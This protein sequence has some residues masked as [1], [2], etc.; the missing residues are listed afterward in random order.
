MQYRTT[1]AATGAYRM[2]QTGSH[3][4]DLIV[5]LL[6]AAIVALLRAGDSRRNGRLDAELAELETIS[7]IM[8]G[9]NGALDRGR[10]FPLIAHLERFYLTTSFQV[11]AIPRQRD[12]L[13]A[14]SRLVARLRGMRDAWARVAR[15]DV[16]AGGGS[17][18]AANRDTNVVL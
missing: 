13:A 8:L 18:S 12:P 2:A 17:G 15:Q 6:D 5:S 1:K 4:L 14:G 16:K 9:L 3:T 11:L 7:R 10:A